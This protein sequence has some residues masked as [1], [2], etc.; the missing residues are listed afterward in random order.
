VAVVLFLAVAMATLAN[1]VWP[2]QTGTRR[3]HWVRNAT[4]AGTLAVYLGIEIAQRRF[5]PPGGGVFRLPISLLRSTIAVCWFAALISAGLRAL[6]AV[7]YRARALRESL[8]I[9]PLPAAAPALDHVSSNATTAQQPV[10]DTA[11]STQTLAPAAALAQ[12]TPVPTMTRRETLERAVTLATVGSLSTVVGYGLLKGA[13][14]LRVRE[15]VVPI[16]SLPSALEGYTIAQ[17]TDI[18]VGIFTGER[19]FAAVIE[20]ANALR[21]DAMV[22]TGDLLDR[23]PKFVPDAMRLFARLRAR[24]G[25]FAILG[26]HDYYTG[27]EPVL[28]GLAQTSIRTLV[29]EHVV[30]RPSDGGI[31]LAGLDELWASKIVPGRGPDLTAALR[32]ANP[33]LA[34]ILLAHNPKLFDDAMGAVDLQL[35]GHTHGGQITVGSAMQGLL[36]YVSGMYRAR[37]STLFVSNGLGFTGLPFRI[38]APPEIVKIVLVQRA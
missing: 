23:S 20:K 36:G 37:N 33:E 3:G 38:N 31:V 35:S 5:A 9:N 4:I 7:G 21:A 29:N 24:D 12:Q 8:K 16:A 30:L 17:L 18:H 11:A 32:G 28:H 10:S 15:V 26:N 13:K 34:K 6:I 1:A 2:R 14:D 22:L 19:D 25:V 27:F